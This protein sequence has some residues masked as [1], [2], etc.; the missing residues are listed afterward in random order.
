MNDRAPVSDP[1]QPAQSARVAAAAATL[2]AALAGAFAARLGGLPLP[3]L[4]GSLFATALVSLM[5]AP[6]R[7]IRYG[8]TIGQV[9]V[10]C[11][12][13][14]Q[15]NKTIILTLVSLVHL[16]AAAAVVSIVV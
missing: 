15:F 10:G 8:R 14:V 2:V 9:V 3:W 1:L 6:I 5:G 4:L 7:P 11:A 12:I 13:G 16:M